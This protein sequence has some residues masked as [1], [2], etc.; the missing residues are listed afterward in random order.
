MKGTRLFGALAAASLLAGC[1]GVGAGSDVKRVAEVQ[2]A[3]GT[4]FTQALTA[5][6]RDFALFEANEMYDW[7]DAGRFA[8]KGLRAAS[9]EVVPPE[10]LT[11]WDLPANAVDELTQ[12]RANLVA[13]LDASARDRMPIEAA[14]AQAKFDCWVEQQEENWQVDDIAACR[15]EFLAALAQLGPQAAPVVVVGEAERTYL[16]FFD[17]DRAEITDAAAD[18]IDRVAAEAM[19]TGNVNVMVTGYTDTSGSASYNQRLSMRRAEAVERALVARG[20][21]ANAITTTGLGENNLLVPTPDGVREPSN[22][23]AVIEFQ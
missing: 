10:E 5:E 1:A 21:P 14:R 13:A 7:R 8:R 18:V 23:R 15:G 11:G 22:R 9:G 3:G 16:V 12:A 17:F 6:Y 4:A 2:P 19:R 20:L